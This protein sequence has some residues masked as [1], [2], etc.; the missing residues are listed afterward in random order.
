MK[1]LNRNLSEIDIYYKV[2]T[3]GIYVVFS[4]MLLGSTGTVSLHMT[5]NHNADLFLFWLC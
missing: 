1:S 4:T 2:I 3:A 5:F